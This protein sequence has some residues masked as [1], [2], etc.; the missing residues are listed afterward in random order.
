MRYNRKMKRIVIAISVG[1]FS[2]LLA[3]AATAR[4]YDYYQAGYLAMHRKM[5]VGADFVTFSSDPIG[6]MCELGLN[7]FLLTMG[8]FGCL[9]ACRDICLEVAGPLNFP[10]LG[11]AYGYPTIFNRLLMMF[12]MIALTFGIL[13]KFVWR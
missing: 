9:M 13:V 6:F 2:G 5:P 12:C 7:I 10:D 11:Q 4:L 8:A 1:A 3:Y